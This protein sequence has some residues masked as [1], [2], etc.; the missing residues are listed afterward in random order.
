MTCQPQHII[1]NA[2]GVER[3]IYENG[4]TRDIIATIML[5]DKKSDGYINR[6]A[7]ECLRGANDIST[8]R[9]VWA[10]V[11]NNVTYKTDTPGYE[12]VKSPGALFHEYGKGDCKSFSVAAVAILRALGYNN[13]YYRFTSYKPGEYTHVYVVVKGRETVVIDSTWRQFNSEPRYTKR[14]DVK[15]SKPA[16]NGIGQPAVQGQISNIIGAG[17]AVGILA[18]AYILTT[19]D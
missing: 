11:R 5:A 9:N 14:L 12:K 10:F 2:R 16:V 6:S 1:K 4:D 3:V 15:A 8:F 7:V 13:I 17:I 19:N 18:L